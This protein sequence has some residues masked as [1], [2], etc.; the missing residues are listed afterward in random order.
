MIRR[1]AD[2]YPPKSFNGHQYRTLALVKAGDDTDRDADTITGRAVPYG[3]WT[4][5]GT[6]VYERMDRGC[7][8]ASIQ[9]NPRLPLLLW[10][11]RHSFP[12]GVAEQWD[13]RADGLYGTWKIDTADP[14]ATEALRKARNGILNGLSVGFTSDE[15][16]TT[17]DLDDRSNLWITRHAA[18]LAEVSLVPTPAY[19]GAMVTDVR[20]IDSR[21]AKAEYWRNYLKANR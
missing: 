13:D 3:T 18:R 9:Q 2:L 21:S 4:G 1:W 6:G 12:I 7:F 19:A 14:R 11:D 20:M 17:F 15:Q 5:L 8:N 10:H 16:D